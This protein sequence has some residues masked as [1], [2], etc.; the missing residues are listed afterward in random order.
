[1][2]ENAALGNRPQCGIGMHDFEGVVGP[3]VAGVK[4]GVAAGGFV[5]GIAPAVDHIG[6]DGDGLS[7]TPLQTAADVGGKQAVLFAADL[8]AGA[9][10]A[11]GQCVVIGGVN[12]VAALAGGGFEGDTQAKVGPSRG[13]E[14]EVFIAQTDSQPRSILFAGGVGGGEDGTPVG[15][16]IVCRHDNVGVDAVGQ[17]PDGNFGFGRYAG[18]FDKRQQEYGTAV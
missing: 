9:A 15:L 14:V 13:V 11:A 1:M 17:Q 16:A 4:D 3:S 12:G 10:G 7:V 5:E 18:A 8:Q 6:G 2:L